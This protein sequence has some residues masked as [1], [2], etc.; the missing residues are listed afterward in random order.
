MFN[1]SLQNYFVKRKKYQR[2][3]GKIL[4]KL[5]K[6][7]VYNSSNFYTDKYVPIRF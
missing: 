2:V 5:T 4:T 3:V 7:R 6:E 1:K